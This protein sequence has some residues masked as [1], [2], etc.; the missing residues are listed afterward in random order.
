M[1]LLSN[2]NKSMSTQVDLK[3]LVIGVLFFVIANPMTYDLV[4]NVVPVK[5]SNGPTQLGVLIHAV[6]FMILAL[7]LQRMRK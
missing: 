1:K 4:D 5:Y 3:V 6:V 7:L 2:L